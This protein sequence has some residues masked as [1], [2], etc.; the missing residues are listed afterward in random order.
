MAEIMD[1]AGVQSVVTVVR[2]DAWGRSLA[3]SIEGALASNGQTLAGAVV[4]QPAASD[5]GPTIAA[6]ASAIGTNDNAGVAFVGVRTEQDSLAAAAQGNAALMAVPWFVTPSGFYRD[7]PDATRSFAGA[8]NMTAI[9]NYVED[10][11]KKSALDAR[12]PGLTF[13][14]YAAYD[15][16]F[17]LGNSIGAVVETGKTSGI[18]A[19]DLK[20][21]VADRADMYYG[22]LGN[23]ML[24]E[25]GDLVSPNTYGVYTIMA[26][27]NMWSLGYVHPMQCGVS[28]GMRVVPFGDVRIGGTMSA[29][30]TIKNAGRMPL[31]MVS[32]SA[33]PWLQT[34]SGAQ[35]LPAGATSVAVGAASPVQLSATPANLTG[36]N[37]TGTTSLTFSLDTSGAGAGD[38]GMAE[39]RVMYIATCQG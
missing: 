25:S 27:T 6:I 15:G 5:W 20:P 3:S 29:E 23:I 34:P 38:A 30:Q 26:P 21:L 12:V 28:L 33:D 31:S 32:I 8:V 2:D 9:V 1:A 36:I 10:S 35:V 22:V 19:A 4:F 7:M 17:I 24:D 16:L 11:A 37:S 18:G 13:Y 14:E 39:Q